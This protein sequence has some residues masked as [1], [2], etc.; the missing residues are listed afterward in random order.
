[1]IIMVNNI[2]AVIPWRFPITNTTCIAKNR[3]NVNLKYWFSNENSVI[4]WFKRCNLGRLFFNKIKNKP[5]S[6]TAMKMPHN[7]ISVALLLK[8]L[9]LKS[10]LIIDMLNWLIIV[11][12][13]TNNNWITIIRIKSALSVVLI[14]FSFCWWKC[15]PNRI[16]TITSKDASEIN[17]YNIEKIT[18]I[19]TSITMRFN[20]IFLWTYLYNKKI[21]KIATKFCKKETHTSVYNICPNNLFYGNQIYV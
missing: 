21:N 7:V 12:M 16:N 4:S 20:V 6:I 14:L 10:C 18:V 11:P 13:A 3:P 17:R 19:R 9:T 5:S 2:V 1:M 15:H 8:I